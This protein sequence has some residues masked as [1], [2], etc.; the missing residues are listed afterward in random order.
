M[1]RQLIA[2]SLLTVSI[3][4][5]L[6]T[7]APPAHAETVSQCRERAYRYYDEIVAEGTPQAEAAQVLHQDLRACEAR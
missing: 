2:A 5:S 6:A 7:I 1:L 4:A 3:V